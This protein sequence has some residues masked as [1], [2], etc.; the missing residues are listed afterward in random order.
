MSEFIIEGSKLDG[1]YYDDR[2][3]IVPIVGDH[4]EDDYILVKVVKRTI[5]AHGNVTIK[6]KDVKRV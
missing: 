6:C 4:F 3:V 2:K 5:N 1:R